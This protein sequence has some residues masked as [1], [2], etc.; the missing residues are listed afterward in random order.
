MTKRILLV[1]PAYKTRYPPFG[2]MKISSYHKMKGDEVVFIKGCKE[3]V[4]FQYWD[5]VYISTLFTWTWTETIKT[6]KFYHDTLFNFSGKCFV[7]GILASLMPDEFIRHRLVDKWKQIPD[8]ENRWMPYVKDWMRI[9]FD[10]SLIESRHLVDI[11]NNKDK[12]SIADK[13]NGITD[14]RLHQLLKFHL[15]EDDIVAQYKYK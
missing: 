9:F 15:E 1:E 4:R 12:K 11:L 10:L 3:D 13:L 14:K 8:Y 2:L 7:G 5:R 6:I